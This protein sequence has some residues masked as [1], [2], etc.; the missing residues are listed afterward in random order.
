MSFAVCYMHPGHVDGAFMDSVVHLITSRR[1]RETVG[2]VIS[3]ET[4][5][6]ICEGRNLLTAKFL[7]TGIE[8]M[9]MLDADICFPHDLFDRLLPSANET[10]IATAIYFA[11]NRHKRDVRPTIYDADLRN[12]S[13]WDTHKTF[14]IGACGAGCMLIHRNV[15]EKIEKPWFEQAPDG[16]YLEDVGFCIN[17]GEAGIKI[18]CDPRIQIGHCKGFIVGQADWFAYKN[19]KEAETVSKV[20]V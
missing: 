3:Q 9:L 15:F 18:V 12:I 14:E 10:T 5:V 17:A 16:N 13:E 6:G 7:Q 4:G 20:V 1:G 2:A 11:W 8:W 19:M